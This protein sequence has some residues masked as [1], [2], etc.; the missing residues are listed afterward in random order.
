MISIVYSTREDDPLFTSHLNKSTV[1]TENYRIT[2][3]Q[4]N[5]IQKNKCSHREITSIAEQHIR[6]CDIIDF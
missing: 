2:M 5:L 1:N 4:E 3:E 6:N